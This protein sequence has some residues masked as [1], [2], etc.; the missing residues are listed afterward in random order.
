[1]TAQKNNKVYTISESEKEV[2][3]A[4][5]Y[6]ICD[7]NGA[8]VAYGKGRT[9]SQEEYENVQARCKLLEEQLAELKNLP[10]EDTKA[11]KG[12]SR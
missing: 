10:E 3:I 5:G 1:M 11:V 7:E 4:R 2:Y 9:V 6:D 8:I 12:K